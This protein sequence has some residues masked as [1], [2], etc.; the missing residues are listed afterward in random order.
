[1]CLNCVCLAISLLVRNFSLIFIS[2]L[3][4][5]CTLTF[6]RYM[7]EEVSQF[8]PEFHKYAIKQLFFISSNG[9]LQFVTSKKKMFTNC[10]CSVCYYSSQKLFGYLETL[11]Y[12]KTHHIWWM[13]ESEVQFTYFKGFAKIATKVAQ[14]CPPE[15]FKTPSAFNFLLKKEAWILAYL[16]NLP[17]P[18]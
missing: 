1:M 8:E 7:L 10:N 12:M 18:T 4:C 16:E 5:L 14:Q 11:S 9:I 2:L 13:H 6:L 17:R 15:C 3:S